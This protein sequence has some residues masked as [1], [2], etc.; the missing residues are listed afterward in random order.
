M[1]AAALIN[2]F[3]HKEANI[4]EYA[5]H[6]LAEVSNE[7]TRRSV[8]YDSFNKRVLWKS[9]SND[10]IRWLDLNQI[11]FAAGT[12]AL[13]VDC[14]LEFEGIIN[15]QLIPYDRDIIKNLIFQKFQ[16]VEPSTI[17]LLNSRGYSLKDVLE[18]IIQHSEKYV[19]KDSVTKDQH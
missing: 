16:E 2:E 8:V 1:R 10:R 14:D 6:I 11:S 17:N 15:S 12:P 4:V 9:E 3:A 5:F 7:T 19:V 18:R 13:M